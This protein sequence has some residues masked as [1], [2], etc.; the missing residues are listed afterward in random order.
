MRAVAPRGK[1]K[2]KRKKGKDTGY[3]EVNISSHK[4]FGEY[5]TLTY[6]SFCLAS[7]MPTYYIIDGYN[8]CIDDLSFLT[9]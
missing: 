2:S 1:K 5:F 4:E 9:V 7:I 3:T 8:S 6:F